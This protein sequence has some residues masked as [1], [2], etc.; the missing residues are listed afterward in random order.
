MARRFQV[1]FLG[2]QLNFILF[3]LAFVFFF[4]L[5]II[6]RNNNSNGLHTKISTSLKIENDF[7]S[8]DLPFD[9]F[10]CYSSSFWILIKFAWN[11]VSLLSLASHFFLP[12]CTR[13]ISKSKIKTAHVIQ[14]LII[15]SYTFLTFTYLICLQKRAPRRRI[16]WHTY[17]HYWSSSKKANDGN[18][19][20]KREEI[21]DQKG[22]T[23][24]IRCKRRFYWSRLH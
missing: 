6:F 8:L 20:Q 14:Y 10:F 9:R 5:R 16:R 19:K 3:V 12:S 2:I 7:V 23:E 21:I 17:S 11:Y 18:Q 13:E 1:Q 24:T 4:L 15:I 22:E